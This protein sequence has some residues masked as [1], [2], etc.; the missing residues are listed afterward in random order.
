MQRIITT[1]LLSLS[2]LATV[3]KA[4]AVE[5]AD[6]G[7]L[8]DGFLTTIHLLVGARWLE[9]DWKDRIDIDIIGGGGFQYQVRGLE[10][11]VALTTSFVFTDGKGDPGNNVE[12][13]AREFSLGVTY[14]FVVTD[15]ITFDVGAGGTWHRISTE[16]DTKEE[17]L[18]AGSAYA[19]VMPHYAITEV[20]DVGVIARYSFGSADSEIVGGG[21][22][23]GGMGIF[24]ALGMRF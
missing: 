6:E 4:A 3:P 19:Q 11:P 12:L 18:D 2:A 23:P 13:R 8:K 17:D 24:G 5:N 10:W 16:T 21:V 15:S 9:G 14:P 1:G 7:L 22:N 20:L